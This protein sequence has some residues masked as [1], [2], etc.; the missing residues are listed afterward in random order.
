MMIKTHS[1]KAMDTQDV[2][3]IRCALQTLKFPPPSVN[4]AQ[5]QIVDL[6]NHRAS[7][8]NYV[9]L[10]TLPEYV[11]RDLEILCTIIASKITRLEH[12]VS[13]QKQQK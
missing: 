9:M 13:A 5:R 3:I 8:I 12:W 7:I 4:H 2:T 10:N 1:S 11:I 6:R